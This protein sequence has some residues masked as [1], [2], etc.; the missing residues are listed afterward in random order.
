MA[1]TLPE[2]TA[3]AVPKYW[4]GDI[5]DFRPEF[6]NGKL[7]EVVDM[8]AGRYGTVVSQRL[9]SGALTQRLY[10]ATVVRIAARVFANTDGFRKENGGQYGYEFNPAAASG[11]VWLTDDDKRDLTGIDPKQSNVIGTATIGRHEPGRTR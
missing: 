6:V 8:I 11:T 10:E 2:V 7:G 3:E 4:D 9:A 5:D 1:T